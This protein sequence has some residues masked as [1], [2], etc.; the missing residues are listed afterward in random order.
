ME[1]ERARERQEREAALSKAI[2][3]AK[4]TNSSLEVWLHPVNRICG[5]LTDYQ[6]PS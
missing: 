3:N 2:K 1:A 6:S 5:D 4:V